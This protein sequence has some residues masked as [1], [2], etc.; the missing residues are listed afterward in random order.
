MAAAS[1][2]QS[3]SV[4][5]ELRSCESQVSKIVQKLL[6]SVHGPV[7]VV[8]AGSGITGAGR[9]QGMVSRGGV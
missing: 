8:Y 3:V 5:A 4:R 6:D 1:P 7:I 9:I 2:S